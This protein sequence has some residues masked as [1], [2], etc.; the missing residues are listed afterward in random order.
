MGNW[1][2]AGVVYFLIGLFFVG[3][4][5][6]QAKIKGVTKLSLNLLIAMLINLFLW[7]AVFM[8]SYGTAITEILFEKRSGVE[9]DDA[10]L[11]DEPTTEM[12]PG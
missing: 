3:M 4:V 9:S 12:P 6:A 10:P 2:I 11:A 5:N 1:I 8:I 7:P